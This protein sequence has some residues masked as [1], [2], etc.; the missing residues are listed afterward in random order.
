[1]KGLLI[2]EKPDLMKKIFAVYRANRDKY[3]YTLD[4]ASQVGHL[5]TLMFPKELDPENYGH[6]YMKNYP[7]IF[8]Y[9][10]KIKSQT[11]DV[12]E[13]IKKQLEENDYD[14]IVHAGDP[15]QEGELLV[16]LTLNKVG[17]KL[18][19]KRFW[20]NDLSEKSI[21][22]ALLNLRDDAEF[23]RLLNA[24]LL[25]QHIDYQYGMNYAP[26]ISLQMNDTCKVGRVKAYIIYI[27]ATREIEIINYVETVSY[28]PMFLYRDLEFVYPEGKNTSEE[29]CRL[30]PVDSKARV[31]E[32]NI[33]T[34]TKKPE[35]L[36][37][38][39]SLQTVAYKE[40]K[41]NAA[42]TLAV[43]QSLYEKK[44]VSYPRTDCEYISTETDLEGI[45]NKIIGN[46]SIDPSLIVKTGADL[47]KDKSYCNDEQVG[48]ESHTAI[49]PT[50][51][52][53]TGL[54]EEK[55][56]FMTLSAEDS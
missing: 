16:H 19:I 4:F 25:R 27:S 2:A 34:K 52:T 49:I 3:D 37:K 45:K 14:F 30:N 31:L 44:M 50:G 11:K 38:L 42:D 17:N 8:P 54:N 41:M 9:K 23:R 56:R 48:K 13:K 18:P 1:M 36:F 7:H 51:E 24:A 6:W 32:V 40:L 33:E 21:H 53:T 47:K 20:T 10:Y 55:Q 39:S 35:K 43:T 46:F 15:D 28:K 26:V 29:A 5:V 22:N 12:Y